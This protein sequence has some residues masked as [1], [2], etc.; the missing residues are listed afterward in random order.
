MEMVRS[1]HTISIRETW[2]LL[3]AVW[4]HNMETVW[5][6]GDCWLLYGDT[7]WRCYGGDMEAPFIWRGLETICRDSPYG[8]LQY[9]GIMEAT[10]GGC[11]DTTVASWRLYGETL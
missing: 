7:V 4:R 8:R 5:R 1:L 3:V 9:G 10:Y 2:R 6:Y 11:M